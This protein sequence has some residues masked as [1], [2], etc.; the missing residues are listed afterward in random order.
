MTAIERTGK[1][2]VKIRAE[3]KGVDKEKPMRIPISKPLGE[4]R[5]E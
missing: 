3:K 4:R 1:N 2:K 5:V